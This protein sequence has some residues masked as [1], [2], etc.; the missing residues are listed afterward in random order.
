MTNSPNFFEQDANE[1]KELLPLL[2][3][4]VPLIVSPLNANGFADYRWKGI[5]GVTTQ[6]ERKT[7]GE[8][9][10][11]VEHVEEQLQR[12]LTKNPDVKLVFMLEGMVVQTELGATIIGG[13]NNNRI[14]TL[15]RRYNTR[16]SGIYSWLFEISNYLTVIQTSGLRESAIALSSMYSH[17]QK[18]THT[19]FKRHIKQIAYTPNPMV[20]TL[21]GASQ[22]LGDKRATNII[23]LM[24]TPWNVWT[25]GYCEHMVFKDKYA[26]TQLD[27]VG[28]G[29]IDNV[30]RS[31]G[32][33]DT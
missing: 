7:W 28:K 14:F 5:D 23:G 33:P 9:L 30:L 3:Q 20:T 22:G 26:A 13:T 12:H 32:R 21:M 24:G 19:T 15:G 25:A 31:I 4:T 6:V 8:L 27:G 17:D 18:D 2:A 10:A 11:N 16:L 1:P 29:I